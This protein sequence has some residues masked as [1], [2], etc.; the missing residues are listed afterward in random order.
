M[1]IQILL[2]LQSLREALGG[3]LNTFFA[4]ITT[5]AVDYWVII[6]ALIIFWAVDKKKGR[7]LMFSAGIGRY[8]TALLKTIFCVYRPWVRD[9]SI[10]PLPHRYI[11]HVSRFRYQR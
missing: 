6:P 7:I 3:T 1:D 5:I 8:L 10:K 2:G 9:P 11:R 4:F